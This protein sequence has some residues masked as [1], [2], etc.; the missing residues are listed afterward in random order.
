MAEAMGAGRRNLE[1][2]RATAC[3]TSTL[4]LLLGGWLAYEIKSEPILEPYVIVVDEETRVLATLTAKNWNP[5]VENYTDVARRWVQLLQPRSIDD[6]TVTSMRTEAQ[7]LTDKRAFERIGN[8]LV[9]RDERLKKNGIELDPIVEAVP[10]PN[11]GPHLGD[12]FAIVNVRWKERKYGPTGAGAWL[13]F[14]ANVRVEL[15]RHTDTG[16][17]R[18]NPAGLYVTDFVFGASGPIRVSE[19]QP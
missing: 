1:W 13:G 11:Y 17:I 9:E 18:D 15:I 4:A 6:V 5:G 3:A 16:Q 10:D 14:F 7:R 12:D 19:A 8:M 2:W